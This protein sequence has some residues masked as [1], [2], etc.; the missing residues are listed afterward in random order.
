MKTTAEILNSADIEKH[1]QNNKDLISMAACEE[2]C[3]A[4]I[5]DIRPIQERYARDASNTLTYMIAP[6]ATRIL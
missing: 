3:T 5:F 1:I 6:H 4:A 2:I